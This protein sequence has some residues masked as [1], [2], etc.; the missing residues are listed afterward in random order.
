MRVILYPSTTTAPFEVFVVFHITREIIEPRLVQLKYVLM[1]IEMNRIIDTPVFKRNLELSCSAF[2]VPRE[3]EYNI[4]K[5][6]NRIINSKR[7][8]ISS[9]YNHKFKLYTYLYILHCAF[10]VYG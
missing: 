1:V 2:F 5:Y 4:I 10:N 9:Y 8:G 3:S 6:N 7:F